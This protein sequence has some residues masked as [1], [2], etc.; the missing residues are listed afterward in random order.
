MAEQ[1][2]NRKHQRYTAK[3]D[4]LLR[5]GATQLPGRTPKAVYQRR[6][7]LGLVKPSA[8]TKDEIELARQG[9][10]PEGRTKAALRCVRN[11]LGITNQT[12]MNAN[13]QMELRF[14]TKSPRDG[15]HIHTTV[16]KFVNTAMILHTAGLDYH[17]I[18][19]QTHHKV[20]QVQ[21]A[22]QLAESLRTK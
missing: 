6:R 14:T 13:G 12:T 2:I 15:E 1:F 4:A 22:I 8:W 16:A 20:A 17:E 5:K 19:E 3:E 21:Q 18:A 11:K 7:E 10:C 9:I